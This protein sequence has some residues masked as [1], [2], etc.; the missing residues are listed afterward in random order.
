MKTARVARPLALG[1]RA[2]FEAVCR[3]LESGY[4]AVP[5]AVTL[6]EV[7]E[8]AY[9]S[10][11]LI[12]LEAPSGTR[13]LIAK[14]L[15][16]CPGSEDGKARQI[17]REH[18]ALVE[19]ARTFRGAPDLR[20]PAPVAHFPDL[21]TVVMETAAGRLLS[22]VIG[23]ARFWPRRATV[24]AIS[25]ACRLCGRWLRHL[26]E[27]TRA[28]A[29][30]TTLD[31]LGPC[32]VALATLA[33]RPVP[34]VSSDFLAVVRSHVRDLWQRL[35]GRDVPVTATHGGLAPYNVIVAPDGRAVTVIDFASFRIDAAQ[36]DYLK[37]RFRI[38]MLAE[39]PSF[40][41]R[42]VGR[43]VEAFREGYGHPVDEESPVARLLSIGLALDQMAAY[44]EATGAPAVS[45]RR[46]LALR[47]R[48]RH[49]HR[50]LS[51]TCHA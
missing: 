12:R 21:Q 1:G 10:T 19:C 35:D 44:V 38:E 20:V 48:F 24:E 27:T 32:D 18:R 34:P 9:S 6:L 47:R 5:T 45:L 36:F 14:T 13:E 31:L 51:E 49:H 42:V 15:A 7:R 4:F 11:G 40:R 26:Q 29:P 25:H 30:A 33:A 28:L 2:V 50:R 17:E 22:E 3:R 39:G 43:L 23:E 46:R 8:H 37:F 16:S 41:R